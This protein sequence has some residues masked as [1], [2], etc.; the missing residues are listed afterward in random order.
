MR[1]PLPSAVSNAAA[2]MSISEPG[3]RRG[4][5]TWVDWLR[6]HPAE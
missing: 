2:A 1:V 5:I 3:S 6:G 4:T